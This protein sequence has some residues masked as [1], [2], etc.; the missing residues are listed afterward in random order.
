MPSS[1]HTPLVILSESN[2]YNHIQFIICIQE[3]RCPE[4]QSFLVYQVTLL[5]C[6]VVVVNHTSCGEV[7]IT[8]FQNFSDASEEYRVSLFAVNAIGTSEVVEYPT[9][10]SMLK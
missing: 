4:F 7:C 2:T 5:G 6:S 3:A 8:T 9:N 1:V 10:I